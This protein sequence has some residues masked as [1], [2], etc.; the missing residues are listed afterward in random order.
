[1]GFAVAELAA[2]ADDEDGAVGLA[3]GVLTFFGREVGVLA[4]QLLGVYEVD[5]LGQEG[6]EL[7]VHLAEVVFSAQDGAVDALH[8]L[9]QEAQVAVFARHGALPVP[10]IDVDA[11]DVVKVFVGAHGIHV[12]DDAEAVGHVVL[13][14]RV[15]LPFGQ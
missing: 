9:A 10:L 12:G 6:F 1:M 2:N 11:V 8:D 13:G 15:T 7:G 5:F 3:D 14:E 4:S